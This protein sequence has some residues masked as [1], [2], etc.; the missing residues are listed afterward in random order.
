MVINQ[1]HVPRCVC[2]CVSLC[3][4]DWT[5]KLQQRNAKTYL[6]FQRDS[7]VNLLKESVHQWAF[8][9]ANDLHLPEFKHQLQTPRQQLS[10]VTSAAVLNRF[11]PVVRYSRGYLSVARCKWFAHGPADA[12]ATPSSLASLKSRII[13][14][15]GACLPR[16]SWKK[17]C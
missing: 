4:Y 7:Q 16:L 12:T 14:L 5:L 15:S 13:Y 6:T 11:G 8:E 10:T 2:V 17:G 3:L 1:P 9:L